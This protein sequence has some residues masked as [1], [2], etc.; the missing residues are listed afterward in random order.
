MLECE[1]CSRAWDSPELVSPTEDAYLAIEIESRC[2]NA[3]DI[4][5]HGWSRCAFHEVPDCSY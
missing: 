5:R 3:E 4:E 2:A 1:E